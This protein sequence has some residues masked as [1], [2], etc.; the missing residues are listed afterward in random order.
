ML[1]NITANISEQGGLMIIERARE[2]KRERVRERARETWSEFDRMSEW[3]IESQKR[4]RI[5]R[6][7]VGG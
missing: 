3:V 5:E 4:E 7:R 2:R 6:E 1:R